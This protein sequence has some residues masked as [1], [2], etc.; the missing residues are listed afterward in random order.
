MKSKDVKN[1]SYFHNNEI[2]FK[3]QR[4]YFDFLKNYF[5]LKKF[6]KINLIINL[7]FIKEEVELARA[8]TDRGLKFLT[9]QKSLKPQ[10]VKD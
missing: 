3:E 8:S 5:Y 6:Y 7:I 10:Q 9:I 2:I 1:Y 4:N